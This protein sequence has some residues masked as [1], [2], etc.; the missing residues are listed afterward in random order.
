MCFKAKTLIIILLCPCMQ[1]YQICPALF[2]QWLYHTMH[3]NRP[4]GFCNFAPLS[5]KTTLI[6]VVV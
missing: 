3:K 4:E 5:D 6:H 2:T 1:L